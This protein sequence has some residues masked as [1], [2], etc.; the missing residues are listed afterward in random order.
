VKLCEYDDGSLCCLDVDY[1]PLTGSDG[2][3]GSSYRPERRGG[4]MGGG[5]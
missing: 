3:S 4:G 5:G 1:N 2:S